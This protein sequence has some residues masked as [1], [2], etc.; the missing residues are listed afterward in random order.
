MLALG[1]PVKAFAKSMD[2][3][4]HICRTPQIEEQ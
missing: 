1:I 3:D 4:L 2:L